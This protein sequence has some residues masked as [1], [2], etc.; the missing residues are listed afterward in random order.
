MVL[1]AILLTMLKRNRWQVKWRFELKPT[2]LQEEEKGLRRQIMRE[3]RALSECQVLLMTVMKH[4][5][6]LL[7]LYL[8]QNRTDVGLHASRQPWLSC[9]AA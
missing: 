8:N 7:T 5:L 2:R 4:P 9:A 6:T 1:D 3:R